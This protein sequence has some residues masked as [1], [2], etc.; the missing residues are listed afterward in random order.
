MKRYIAFAGDIYYPSGGMDDIV[1]FFDT[2]EEARAA[3]NGKQ[4]PGDRWGWSQILDC[5]TQEE[6]E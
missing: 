1:G 3:I 2:V 5:E 4:Q 6:A